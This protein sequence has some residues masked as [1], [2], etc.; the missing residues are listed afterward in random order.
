MARTLALLG[1]GTSMV[2][3]AVFVD[4]TRLVPSLAQ[5][6]FF[7]AVRIDE[8]RV[9]AFVLGALLVVA[10]LVR[11]VLARPEASAL[12]TP[13]STTRSWHV[14]ALA[15][16]ALAACATF[17]A[18]RDDPLTKDT[19]FYLGEAL[20][21]ARQGG[22]PDL[23][24]RCF[25]GTW[26]EDN[27]HPLY[28]AL[29]APWAEES[30]RALLAARAVSF[31]GAALTLW[32]TLRM[33]RRRGGLPAAGAAAVVLTTNACFLEHS[34][35]V[36][37]ESWWSACA[38]AAFDNATREDL[39]RPALRWL[40]VGV[41][42]G[43]AFLTKG[44]GVLLAIGFG[45]W[46]AFDQRRSAW[47]ALAG[48]ALGFV[49]GAAPLLVRNQLRFGDALWNVNSRRAFWLD[50]WEQ[51][52]D[53]RALEAASAAHYLETHTVAEML[54]RLA[55]GALKVSVHVLE[56]CAPRAPLG[57]L[58]MAVLAALVVGVVRMRDERQRS[59]LAILG[60]LWFASFSWYAQVA[61]DPRFVAVLLPLAMP[62]LATWTARMRW[63]LWTRNAWPARAFGAV[64][65]VL[66][67][68][69]LAML[70]R[71]RWRA[72]TPANEELQRA[73]RALTQGDRD[74]I[75]MLGPSGEWGFDWDRT[76]L[77][78]RRARPKDAR[79]L[80]GWL[81]SSGGERLRYLIVTADPESERLGDD[82]VRVEAD[83]TL[84]V[85]REPAPW[86]AILMI[87]S[88]APRA[89]LFERR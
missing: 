83:G 10:P 24:R 59:L 41:L 23:L 14:E 31:A 49:A 82:W 86:R 27:R 11:R 88:D 77:A 12:A 39:R 55:R 52:F 40:S 36:A 6:W 57:A 21:I 5:S 53:P 73:L 15:L 54:A 65:A 61:S 68:V 51:F 89:I 32:L 46:V 60:G 16:A 79:E 44:T 58:A 4:P 26:S 7:N 84:A 13:A 20:D 30:G 28:L 48:L 69:S 71:S 33:C 74:A 63:P 76:L 67:I 64:A 62:G 80:E 66:A 29:I 34:V 18:W 1:V 47:R 19:K 2:L 85:A 45:L 9:A 87:P 72:P 35:S 17:V 43:L 70:A 22:V 50:S 56:S 75:Y 3:A 25:D 37:C 78:T 38:V 42:L 8:L 81:A